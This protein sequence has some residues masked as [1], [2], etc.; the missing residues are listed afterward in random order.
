MNAYMSQNF[1]MKL[2]DG[3]SNNGS[4]RW[5]AG[6]VASRIFISTINN[7]K[8]TFTL[9]AMNSAN[10][11]YDTVHVLAEVEVGSDNFTG[12][13]DI[14]IGI[15]LDP[16]TDQI[17]YHCYT[18][19]EYVVSF[20]TEL[21]TKTNSIN[22]L[23]FSGY[24]SAKNSGLMFDDLAFGYTANGTWVFDECRHEGT[25]VVYAPTCTT[26]GYT[27]TVCDKCGHIGISDVIPA[28]G[29]TEKEGPTCDHGSLCATCGEYYGDALGH[30]GGKPT[31][32]KQP[33]CDRCGQSY[34]SP[35]H[36]VVGAT[37]GAASYCKA[38]GTVLGEKVSHKPVAYIKDDAIVYECEYCKAT[39]TLEK[40]YFQDGDTSIGGVVAL[41]EDASYELDTSGGNYKFTLLDSPKSNGKAWVWLPTN[42]S[43]NDDFEG[44]KS[45][46]VGVLSFTLDVYTSQ[47]FQV[48]FID[49]DYRSGGPSGS[50]WNAYTMQGIFS[51]GAPVNNVV[52][53]KGWNNEELRTVTVT[54]DNQYTGEFDVTIG[55][56]LS[57]GKIT[58]HYYL[59]GEYVSSITDDFKIAS[60]K[61]DGVAFLAESKVKGSGYTLDN[62]SFGYAKPYDGNPA[63]V[64]PKD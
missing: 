28:F 15:V 35:A 10:N 60:G 25:A 32:D 13:V 8:V 37:C 3:Q 44:F 33:V 61:I 6:G 34:G 21:T 41:P 24:T 50:F 56:E 64:K 45:G 1:D 39:Y 11:K 2:L 58:L 16:D 26:D 5:N 57:G 7:G 52:S 22:S 40:G 59:D 47:S 18:N 27:K 4:D 14:V 23:Y 9:E 12:W 48:H 36:D 62:V 31:C 43:G 17:T 19:G 29:H 30:T 51:V 42:V 54:D 49:S 38:C 55:I 53:I 20:S 46:T 63:P